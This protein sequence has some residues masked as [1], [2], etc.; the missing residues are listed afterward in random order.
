VGAARSEGLSGAVVQVGKRLSQSAYVSYEH[1]LLGLESVVKLTYAL[2]R[3]IS[4]V[5]RAGTD[6][7]VD[8]FYTFSFD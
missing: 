5:A 7:A 1:S 6:N 2:S 8:V 4:V 3:R